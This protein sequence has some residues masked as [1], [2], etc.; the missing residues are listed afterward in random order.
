M[1]IDMQRLAKDQAPRVARQLD[2]AAR[3]SL[4]E[5]EFRAK[6]ANIFQKFADSAGVT[7]RRH[8]EYAVASGR[9]DTVYN[10]LVIEYK[11][12]GKLT[13]GHSSANDSAIEQ[14]IRYITDIATKEHQQVSRM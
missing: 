6:A 13:E 9:A 8:D 2:E 11:A 14:I 3:E 7:L 10:R 12:P 1:P 5:A 4:N